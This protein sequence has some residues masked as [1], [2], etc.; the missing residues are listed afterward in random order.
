VRFDRQLPYQRQSRYSEH[1]FV[2]QKN[3]SRRG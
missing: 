1:A 3:A 2:Y